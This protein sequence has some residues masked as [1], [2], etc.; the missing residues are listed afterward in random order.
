MSRFLSEYPVKEDKKSG[1]I[2]NGEKKRNQKAHA[3]VLNLSEV[4]PEKFTA[5]CRFGHADIR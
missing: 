2:A 5:M 1:F 3:A 4:E